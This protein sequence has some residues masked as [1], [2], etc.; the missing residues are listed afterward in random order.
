MK[1][2]ELMCGVLCFLFLFSCDSTRE[3]ELVFRV[4]DHSHESLNNDF[5]ITTLLKHTPEGS[6][7]FNTKKWRGDTSVYG[8]SLPIEMTVKEVDELFVIIKEELHRD[9]IL[10]ERLK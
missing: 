5:V 4:F 8:Y 6:F 7:V 1:R 2:F 9:G 10:I 3:Q